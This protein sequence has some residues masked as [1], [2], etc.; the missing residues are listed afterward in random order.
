VVSQNKIILFVAQST[1]MRSEQPPPLRFNHDFT[2]QWRVA[3]VH[4]ADVATSRVSN[5]Q[6]E[7]LSGELSFDIR[8]LA[9][10]GLS[11][12][13]LRPETA[14]VIELNRIEGA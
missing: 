5:D 11:L 14:I 13:M 10:G 7:L 8:C 1:Y 6:A 12:P 9:E 4:P 2:G 3:A